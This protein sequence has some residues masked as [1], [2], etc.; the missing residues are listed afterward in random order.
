MIQANGIKWKS[1]YVTIEMQNSPMVFA[2][3]V[4]RNITQIYLVTSKV[5]LV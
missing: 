5:Q 2:R 3:I 1:K 4:K